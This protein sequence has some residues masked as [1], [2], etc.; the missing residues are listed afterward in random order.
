MG[1]PVNE[2]NY[3]QCA[4]HL[5]VKTIQWGFCNILLGSENAAEHYVMDNDVRD[6]VGTG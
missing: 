6:G 4:S 3:T 5:G 2:T 1:S